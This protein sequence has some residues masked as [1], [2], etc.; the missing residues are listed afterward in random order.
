MQEKRVLIT[1]GAGFLGSH[2]VR[3]ALAGGA[4][5]VVNVDLLTYA[6]DLRRLED[7][8]KD[9]RYSFIRADVASV[10]DMREVMTRHRPQVVIHAAAESHVTRSE[11][12]PKL[13]NRTNVQ[14]TKALLEAA[15]FAEP[16]RFVHVSTDEVYGPVIEGAFR[17]DEKPEGL[18]KATSPYAQS[19]SL[20]DDIARS[21]SDRLS[22]VVARPTNAFGPHQFPEKAFARWVTRALRSE[23]MLVWG[24][25]LY[26]RQWL[27]AED[28]AAAMLLLAEQGTP[29]KV[30]N[31]GPTHDPEITNL[32]LARWIAEQIGLSQDQVRLTDYDRPDH[33]RRY[34]VD[35]SRILKLGWQP[36]DVWAQFAATVDWYRNNRDWWEPHIS[37]AESIYTDAAS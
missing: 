22:V 18:G 31:V 32:Q 6:G 10:E 21:F 1:G 14:G 17:E 30:Y 33:D 34:S 28:F 27:Y 2:C 4:A 35:A 8:D 11:E 19:K 23:P 15:I 5:S 29:G 26:I 9:P 3:R 25:G 12:A 36:G 20:A 7:V 16:E 37:E 13:F 24:D